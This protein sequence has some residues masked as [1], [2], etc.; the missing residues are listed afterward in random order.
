MNKHICFLKRV[1]RCALCLLMLLFTSTSVAEDKSLL[2]SSNFSSVNGIKL[3]YL[4]AG[5]GETVIILH[6]FPHYAALWERT[7]KRLSQDYHVVVP[8]NRGYG[9]SSKPKGV[10]AYKIDVLAA[11]VAKLIMHIGNNEKVHLIGH[12][13]G[14][15]LAWHVAETYPE[16]IDKLVVIN[17]PPLSTFLELLVNNENQSKASS[18]MNYLKSGKFEE[19]HK[20]EGASL[21]Q[22]IGFDSLFNK[23]LLDERDKDIFFKHW[24]SIETLEAAINWYRANIPETLDNNF[25]PF[26]LSKT[27]ALLI[28]GENERVF[29]PQIPELLAEGVENYQY[30]IVPNVGHSPFLENEATTSKIIEQF[31]SH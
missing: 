5:Q 25:A 20:E 31:L 27:P 28:W 7:I 23:Q 11:D 21:I 13:W 12:D 22:A 6:G 15:T 18:Y 1:Y 8:D 3:H 10:D 30:V 9:L 29:V 19:K 17:A 16:L 24:N 2:I 14:G 4:S 26:T